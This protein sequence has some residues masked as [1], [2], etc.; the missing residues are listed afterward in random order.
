[1]LGLEHQCRSV[2][3]FVSRFPGDGAVQE[4]PRVKLQARL[5]GR[6]VEYAPGLR[7]YDPCRVDHPGAARVENEIV[8]V[9]FPVL[10]LW[11][12]LVDAVPYSPRGPEV[13]RCV[14]APG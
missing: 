4:V 14:S 11:V 3:I 6:D 5:S 7:L 2:G 8:V 9:A 10:E 12:W 13:A 1:M